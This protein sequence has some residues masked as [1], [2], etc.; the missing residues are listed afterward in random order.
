MG[1]AAM[2]DFPPD[3]FDIPS[4]D[5]FL[6][7]KAGKPKRKAPRARDGNGVDEEPTG[8]NRVEGKPIIKIRGGIL[9]SIATQGEEAL[10]SAAVPLYQRANELFRPIISEV[11]AA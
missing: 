9:D 2:S 1:G 5:D 11:D 4:L 7:K 6:D 8:E 3:Y 10:R